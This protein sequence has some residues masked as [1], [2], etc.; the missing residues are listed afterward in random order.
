MSGW[1]RKRSTES[2]D[3]NRFCSPL[4]ISRTHTNICVNATTWSL[5]LYTCS[6]TSNTSKAR[7]DPGVSTVSISVRHFVVVDIV[8]AVVVAAHFTHAVSARSYLLLFMFV[9]SGGFRT[10]QERRCPGVAH[11]RARPTPVLGHQVEA[12]RCRGNGVA[13]P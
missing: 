4:L 5:G 2:R 12:R 7:P 9:I 11:L 6:S 1:G 8:D 13:A 3:R 10:C